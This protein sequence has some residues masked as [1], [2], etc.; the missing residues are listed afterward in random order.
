MYLSSVGLRY[1][2]LSIVSSDSRSVLIVAG[3]PGDGL[4][5]RESRAAIR[6]VTRSPA[7]RIPVM[8]D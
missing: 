8:H 4:H 5:L 1:Q 6:R 2:G 3:A 7:R